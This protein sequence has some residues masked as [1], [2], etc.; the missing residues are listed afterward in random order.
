MRAGDGFRKRRPWN[1]TGAQTGQMGG[2]LLAV[3]HLHAMG[4]TQRHQC[5]Q[6][7]LG[8][9][10]YPCEHAFTVN[11]SAQGNAIQAA[12]KLAMDPGFHAVRQTALM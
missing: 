8:G 5:S 11:R 4:A 12:G 7:S 1:G 9:I 6:C 2:F 3:D 10:R